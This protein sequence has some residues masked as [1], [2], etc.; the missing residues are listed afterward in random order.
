MTDF[1]GLSIH[2]R[3]VTADDGDWDQARQAW[4]L[5]ADQHPAAIAV[6]Q[7]AADVS[8]VIAFARE[9]GLR[10]TVQSTGHGATALP[11]LEGTILIKTER[12]KGIDIDAENRT[13]RVE[14]GVLAAELGGA[15]Q[16]K[17]LCW[18][19]GT[20]PDVGVVGYTLGGGFSW[21]GRRYGFAC[22]RVIAI[23]LVTA[24]GEAR[25]VD[26]EA[27]P[28]L[29]W[30]LR[31]GGGGYAIVTALHLDLLDI[32]EV[33]AGALIFPAEVGTEGLR[34]ARDWAAALSEDVTPNIRFLTPPPL[35]DVPEPI[36]GKPL[37]VISGA[38]IGNEADGQKAIA[39]LRE[40][41]EPI[42]DTFA[43]I[44]T[45][46]LTRIDMDPEQ[47]V[48]GLVHSALIRELPD[49]AIDAF[50]AAAGPDSDSPLLAASLRQ[51]GGAL[52][53]PA[54]NAGALEKLD[55][56]FLVAGIGV[57]MDPGLRDTINAGLD[58][59]IQAMEPW[60]ADGAFFNFT[61]RPCDV[62]ALLPQATCERLAHVKRSWDPDDLILANHSVALAP[63]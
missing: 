46:G 44:P 45:S 53:R 10:V 63:A 42:M 41:G 30:A 62:D 31:G 29:F 22:N 32:S 50:V 25:Q 14:A 47:P 54:E 24:D 39:P 20:S 17:D 38:C 23:E 58:G 34:A 27:T 26:M 51:T 12:M 36:R 52:A 16:E 4:N 8:K 13:A 3:V 15:A 55:G 60:V 37:F 21:F 48:P 61:E 49:E 11:G 40:I 28:D 9:N 57:L 35:P 59:L 56:E 33:Y 6:V 1:S 43:Q 19:P 18:L 7:S 2:G 5:T